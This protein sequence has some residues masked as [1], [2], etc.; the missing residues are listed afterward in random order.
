MSAKYFE[1][2]ACY[3]IA[4]YYHLQDT[5]AVANGRH[6]QEATKITLFC[7]F[8]E[9]NLPFL[10]PPCVPAG[11]ELYNVLNPLYHDAFQEDAS[12]GC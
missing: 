3:S 9:K 11:T 1:E 5:V 10:A 6:H 8:Y 4:C 12:E 7:I 2:R